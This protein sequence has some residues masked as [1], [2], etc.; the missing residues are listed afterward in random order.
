MVYVATSISCVG[1]LF[2]FFFA[3]RWNL[4]IGI[5][6]LV[7]LLFTDVVFSILGVVFFALPVFS[8]IAKVTPPKVEGTVYATL[9]GMADFAFGV[10]S[11]LVANILN[12]ELVGVTKSKMKD[13]P[14]LILITLVGSM[15]AFLS[16]PLIPT[17]K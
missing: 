15:L 9:S 4:E 8:L 5:S 1:A 17:K 2:Q 11:P 3:K 12:S 10:L 16:V 7:F 13:Y 14:Y 6:D